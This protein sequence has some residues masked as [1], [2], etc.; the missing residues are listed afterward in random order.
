MK[1]IFLKKYTSD[2]VSFSLSY[3]KSWERAGLCPRT[4][5]PS[6]PRSTRLSAGCRPP[7]PGRRRSRTHGRCGRP[8]KKMEIKFKLIFFVFWSGSGFEVKTVVVD[9]SG[10]SS[11]LSPDKESLWSML[12]S[13]QEIAECMTDKI[14]KCLTIS[15]VFNFLTVIMSSACIIFCF[16]KLFWTFVESGTCMLMSCMSDCDTKS[17]KAT[18][19]CTKRSFRTKM[20]T[21]VEGCIR[22]PLSS[23]KRTDCSGKKE[24]FAEK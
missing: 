18:S 8:G 11:M 12:P 17:L 24:N 13:K 14:T 16:Y 10:I 19:P 21:R 6:R 15:P 2:C 22:S 4:P 1:D 9:D 23:R 20:E 5:P 7:S 3:T